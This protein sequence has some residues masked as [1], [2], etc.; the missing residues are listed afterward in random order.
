MALATNFVQTTTALSIGTSYRFTDSFLS[1]EVNLTAKYDKFKG[2]AGIYYFTETGHQRDVAPYTSVAAQNARVRE[3]DASAIFAEGTYNV[4]E[5]V[6]LTAG[7]RY[8]EEKADFTQFYFNQVGRTPQNAKKTF[9]ATTPKFGIDWQLTPDTLLYA[10]YTK[11][12]K[13]G[14][15]NAVNPTTNIGGPPGTVAGPTPY[16]PEKVT[17]YEAGVK[18]TSD[19]RRIRVNLAVFQADYEGVQLPVFFPGTANSFTSNAAGAKVR[20][21]EIEPTW[22]INDSFQIYAMGSF[23]TNKYTSPFQCS[24]YNTQ[25]VNC[26]NVKLKGSIPT[27]TSVGF[28]FSPALHVKGGITFNGSWDHNSAYFNNVSNTLPI[29]QTPKADLFNASVRWDSDDGHWRVALEGKN[30]ADKAYAL[31]T[32]QIASAV[33]PSLTVYP[34]DPRTYDLRIRFNF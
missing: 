34:N 20:G 13:S 8:T 27:K 11:G 16:D 25:I 6:G 26:Q 5:T 18:F 29:V 15:F 19:D 24:L 31:E 4:T 21:I 32:L 33:Q 9:K 1:E 17:S 23:E 30:L 3:T 12:F 10:T 2:V 14:G 28:E 22:R 7:I